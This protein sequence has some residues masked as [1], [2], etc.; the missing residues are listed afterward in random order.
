MPFEPLI[1][2]DEVDTA[3]ALPAAPDRIWTLYRPGW[4]RDAFRLFSENAAPPGCGNL[5]LLRSAE[6]ARVIL[7]LLPPS[8]GEYEIIECCLSG[9]GL[10][11]ARVTGRLLGYDVVYPDGDYYSAVKNGLHLNPHPELKARFAPHLNEFGLF[12]SAAPIA[13]FLQ[14]FRRL[15]PSET[16]ADFVVAE[17]AKPDLQSSGAP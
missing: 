9:E 17:L 12:A 6:A 1:V 14:E 16:N 15:V 3:V 11:S 13:E 5:P 7:S 4:K 8:F 10:H 2:D